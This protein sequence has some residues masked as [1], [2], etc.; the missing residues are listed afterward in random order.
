MAFAQSLGL[1]SNQKS[2]RLAHMNL[3]IVF[4]LAYLML[5]FFLP[6]GPR[7]WVVL[8]I[9]VAI[10]TFGIIVER[11]DPGKT[12]HYYISLPVSCQSF[13]QLCGMPST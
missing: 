9:I 13:L 10:I 6:M 12:N 7:H 11:N 4:T 8:G 2:L 1:P 3:I 5:T